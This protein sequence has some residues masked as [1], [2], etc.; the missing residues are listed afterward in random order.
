MVS[1]ARRFS[2]S[3]AIVR[4]E[5]QRRGVPHCHIVL[6]LSDFDFHYVSRGR[7]A[8]ASEFRAIVFSLWLRSLKGFDYDLNLS[9]F[10]RRGIKVESLNSNLAIF[11]YLCDHSSKMKKSQLGFRGKQWTVINR[12][13]LVSAAGTSIHF[14]DLHSKQVFFR[15]IGR[16][17]RFFVPCKCVFGRKL[18][19]PFGMR[20]VIFV[21]RL[22]SDRILT[23]LRSG[24][25]C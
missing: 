16:V 23:A 19:R 4:H 13:L 21:D 11:R 15:H 20:S 8:T 2:G 7:A 1:F 10:A 14:D 12:H 9:A 5:L 24:F 6:Y 25:I 22:T 3:V 17:T 18:S